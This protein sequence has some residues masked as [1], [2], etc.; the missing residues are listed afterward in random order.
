MGFAVPIITGAISGI[1]AIK[2]A[3][4]AGKQN[5]LMGQAQQEQATSLRQGRTAGQGLL[6]MGLPATQNALQYY[7]TLLRGSRS[8]MQ[9]ATAGP[10]AQITDVY[11]GAQRGLEHQGVRGGERQ[12]ALAELNRDRAAAVAGLT[13]GQQGAAA[14]ALGN[15]GGELTRQGLYGIEGA[16]TGFGN[17]A[18]QAGQQG[19]YYEKNQREDLAGV[20][21]S[22]GEIIK[23]WNDRKKPGYV[24]PGFG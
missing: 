2:N 8:A 20:G 4:A 10:A 23:I 24:D 6:Q 19:Q 15:L 9:L 11:R 22:I 12:T 21:K 16:A 17:L 7:A 3:R 5:K 13:T 18:T 1:S 14:S